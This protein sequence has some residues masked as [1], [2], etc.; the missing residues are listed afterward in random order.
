MPRPA[1]ASDGLRVGLLSTLPLLVYIAACAG[2]STSS[3]PAD[4]P[5]PDSSQEPG[6]HAA[7][8]P[9]NAGVTDA[10][11]APPPACGVC[12]DYD[13]D[14]DRPKLKVSAI[15]EASG[16]AASRAHADTYYVHNDSGDGPRVFAIDAQGHLRAEIELT[17]ASASDWEDIAVGPCPTG[18]C[19]YVADIGDNSKVRAE[20][21]VYR[22]PE[23]GSFPPAGDAGAGKLAT[24]FDTFTIR[25]P[26]AEKTDAETLIVDPKTGDLYI[27]NKP[28]IG[29]AATLFRVPAPLAT[30]QTVTAE[31]VKTLAVPTAIDLQV[32]GG[33]AHPCEPMV[34]LR[35]YT[36][37]LEL[38]APA[39]GDLRAAFDAMPVARPGRLEQQGE[40][41]GFTRDG[42]GY[43][44][45]SEGNAPSLNFAHC[46]A[47]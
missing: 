2:A 27:V 18:Q 19:V 5:E 6:P 32:T 20:V 30:G 23:P 35:T 11:T 43:V 33:D 22:F 36:R 38:R 17:G 14:A 44:T 1:R 16:I 21:L 46:A 9:A 29:V 7:T 40:A 41:V 24:A 10:S 25:Y 42:K 37:V 47:P 3:V 15:D 45:V 26:D 12:D 13:L 28:G 31:R 4:T 39:G 8:D 34:I